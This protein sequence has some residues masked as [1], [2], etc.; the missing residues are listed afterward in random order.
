MNADENW[1]RILGKSTFDVH[2]K[3]VELVLR[4]FALAG[5]W[6]TYEQPLKEFLNRTM[7]EERNAT[8]ARVSHFVANFARVAK[9]IVDTL[10]ERPFHIRGPLNTAVLDSVF[11]AI[12]AAVD[13]VPDGLK[14]RYAALCRNEEFLAST[15]SGT[16][17]V[18]ALMK[19]FELAEA[20]L[21][22]GA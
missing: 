10:G 19:R 16:S 9:L 3:D 8:S 6:R 12:L 4:L 21:T 17:A 18:A 22:A 7:L 2:Q 20:Y 1:R 5:K 15:F 13:R 11:C 14:L